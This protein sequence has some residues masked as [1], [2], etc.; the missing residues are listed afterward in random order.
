M[1]AAWMLLLTAAAPGGAPASP[2]TLSPQILFDQASTAAAQDDC[3]TAV[4]LFDTLERRHA[5]KAGSIPDAVVAVRKGGCLI[6][7]NRLVDGERSIQ[8]GL[9]ILE[10]AGS[11]FAGEVASATEVLG[12]AA[13]RYHDYDK[14][15]LHYQ[16]SL[17][18]HAGLGRLGTLA[19]LARV[20]AFDGGTASLSYS[21]EGIALISAMPQKEQNNES[22]VAFH[23]FHARALLNQGK[24]QDG[25]AELKQAL[26][27][28]GGLTWRTTPNEAS[29]RA[30][31]GMAASL[32]GRKDDARLYLAYTGAGRI[33]SSSRFTRGI[34]MDPPL[35]GEETGLRPDDVAVVEF[36]IEDDGQVSDAQTVYSRGNRAVASA[37]A[38]AVNDWYWSPD[39]VKTIPAFYRI[40]TRVEM[41]CSTA[42]AGAPSIPSPGMARFSM[43]ATNLLPMLRTDEPLPRKIEKLRLA[44]AQNAFA[45]ASPARAAA[46]GVIA[47]VEV[48]PAEMR[49]ADANL[50]IAAATEAK[51]P[52]EMTN[53]L[54]IVSVTGGD[55]RL[56]RKTRAALRALAVEPS[57]ASDPLSAATALMLAASQY[58]GGRLPDAPAML[59]RVADDGR[60]PDH[61]PLRQAARV[62][63]ANLAAAAGD[64]AA[65][66]RY[67]ASTGLTE[68]QCALIGVRPALRSSGA[69][70]ADY[71]LEALRMGFEGWVKLEFDV[72]ADG[73]TAVARAIVAYPPLIFVN[74]ASGM[75]KNFRYEA[76]YRPG[77]GA[78]C[79]ANRET[80]NFIRP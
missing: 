17:D 47:T 41:R 50:A 40:G 72:T 52:V 65:A 60:L 78:A 4:V 66:Q 6:R 28:S 20:T 75:A 32:V 21:A 43:W 80:V 73:R 63:L 59:Q 5:L 22:L 70:S 62:S 14:A 1:A 36:S 27:L 61:H 18:L 67:F 46:L 64:G 74:A 57:F 69:S 45:A 15:V 9:P 34:S 16:R 51:A 19:K 33:E 39:S 79:T 77:G 12:D 49:S 13:F 54:R 56:D 71:P 23:T 58:R 37:F 7:T 76:S 44:L 11:E 48:S 55:W 2:E 31:L 26:K 42:G 3:K 35:C 24:V 10:K 68:Q 25:Y 38:S 30:D 29:M 53:W 8:R